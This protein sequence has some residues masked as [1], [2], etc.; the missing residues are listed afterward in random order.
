MKRMRPEQ[1]RQAVREFI[2]GL[3]HTW[4]CRY[5]EWNRDKL[6]IDLEN[7]LKQRRKDRSNG[8]AK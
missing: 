5:G 1:R 8:K 4:T 3:E 6:L 2:G 7:E